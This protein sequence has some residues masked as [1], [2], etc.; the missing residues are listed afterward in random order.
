MR[1]VITCERLNRAPQAQPVIAMTKTMSPIPRTGEY[2][3]ITIINGS[4]GITR[5]RLM[6]ND[7]TSSTQPCM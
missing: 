3:A 4:A 1:N 7:R 2:A 5:A 6:K